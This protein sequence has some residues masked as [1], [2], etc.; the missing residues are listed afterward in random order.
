MRTRNEDISWLADLDDDRLYDELGSALFP[1]G[2]GFGSEDVGRRRRLA[3]RWLD[4]RWDQIRTTVC[5]TPSVQE[6]IDGDDG[7]LLMEVAA[8]ADAI[9]GLL[10]RPT[11]TI[12]AVKVVRRGLRRL[13][14]D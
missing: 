13:C 2:A 5:R 8:V 4:E 12:V 14:V 10:G 11:A 3:E 1:A 9:A 7:D 6:L